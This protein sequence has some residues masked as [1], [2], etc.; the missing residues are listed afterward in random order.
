MSR[1]KSWES[2]DPKEERISDIESYYSRVSKN[3]I[4]NITKEVL[5][6]W[7]LPH[8]NE[9][10]S[11]KNYSWIDL[12]KVIFKVIELNLIEIDSIEIIKVNE[13]FVK[14]Y[15]VNKFA[16][17][18]RPFWRDNGT[19]EVLPI[20]IDSTSFIKSKPENSEIKGQFQ[21]I[22]GHNRLGTLLLLEREGKIK[23]LDS[24]KFYLMTLK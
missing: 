3:T 10:N 17:Y 9:P 1:H 11:V 7:I 8:Y 2:Y 6:Q 4:G 16:S 5:Y 18:H 12:D 19:W 22:E 23:V 15:P 21:L 20:L 24:H 13:S 14:E